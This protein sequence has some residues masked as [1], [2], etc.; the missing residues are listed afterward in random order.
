[1]TP[2]LLFDFDGTI[3]DS[4]HLGL[5]IAN[6]LA[7]EFGL[8]KIDDAQFQILRSMSIPKALRELKIPL[9]KVPKLI[10][11]VLA[12]YRHQIQTLKRSEERRVGKE[13]R[14][15]W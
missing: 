11:R 14:Y 10:P 1:M 15:R 3:A 9:Y 13:C 2:F 8:S 4:I 7:E 12:E 5:S 6:E